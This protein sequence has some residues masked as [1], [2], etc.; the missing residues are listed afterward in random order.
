MGI[1][2]SNVRE[3]HYSSVANE[4]VEA[5]G[6]DLVFVRGNTSHSLR[7]HIDEDGVHVGCTTLTHAAWRLLKAKVMRA[8]AARLFS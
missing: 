6:S 2:D 1:A 4:T 3:L 5:K 8:K 7:V